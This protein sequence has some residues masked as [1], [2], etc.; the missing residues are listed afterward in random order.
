MINCAANLCG[1]VDFIFG[2]NYDSNSRRPNRESIHA[3]DTLI[4]E[5]ESLS[6]CSPSISIS[7][8]REKDDGDLWLK[9]LRWVM[10]YIYN[11]IPDPTG[12]KV[13]IHVVGEEEWEVTFQS[14]P[15]AKYTGVL[16]SSGYKRN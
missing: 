4:K 2:L 11:K 5:V 13:I 16:L 10:N 1:Q 12:V 9:R 3:I 6:C 15:Q 8:K 7:V 14:I